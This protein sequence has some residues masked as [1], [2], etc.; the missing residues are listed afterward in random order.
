MFSLTLSPFHQKGVRTLSPRHGTYI[1]PWSHNG[2]LRRHCGPDHYWHL[3]T[4]ERYPALWKMHD[5]LISFN[6]NPL[7]LLYCCQQWFILNP[8]P[9]C[10]I[11]TIT[12]RFLL[13]RLCPNTNYWLL[14][15]QLTQCLVSQGQVLSWF[16][17]GD[18]LLDLCYVPVF[19][20]VYTYV[21]NL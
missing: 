17:V 18:A 20:G 2:S 1:L 15:C 16:W 7:F 10:A 21:V 12:I 9:R 11:N 14:S 3:T 6:A 8:I 19:L 4:T 5:D 13:R